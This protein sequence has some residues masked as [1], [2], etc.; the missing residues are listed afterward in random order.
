MKT[1]IEVLRKGAV[2]A[3]HYMHV[4]AQEWRLLVAIGARREYCEAVLSRAIQARDIAARLN[5]CAQEQLKQEV[6]F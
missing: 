6:G 4:E 3:R 2:L 1:S 5:K